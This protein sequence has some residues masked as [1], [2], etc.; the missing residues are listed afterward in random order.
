M[1]RKESF[2]NLPQV[3]TAVFT[4]LLHLPRAMSSGHLSSVLL[5]TSALLHLP[6]ASCHLSLSGSD[7]STSLVFTTTLLHLPAMTSGH[8]C[9]SEAGLTSAI[10]SRLIQHCS[11]PLGSKTA[12]CQV[13]LKKFK[14]PPKSDA[15]LGKQHWNFLYH[16]SE[17]EYN[18]CC[19]VLDSGRHHHYQQQQPEELS[20]VS[21]PAG[22]FGKIIN[23]LSEKLCSYVQNWS[24]PRVCAPQFVPNIECD[25][26]VGFDTKLRRCVRHKA[27]LTTS[28]SFL[29]TQFHDMTDLLVTQLP[30]SSRQ[31]SSPQLI[32]V[33]KTIV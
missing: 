30:L 31:T 4:T 24:V 5:I 32:I 25:P 20:T 8:P 21:S 22:S 7:L 9:L 27:P 19:K 13:S 2:L 6:L 16:H 18:H 23:L 33:I 28:P 15:W 11:S 17:T 1:K 12:A 3:S 29:W 14:K 10:C 26:D